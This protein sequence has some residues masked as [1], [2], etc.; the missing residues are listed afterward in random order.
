MSQPE[1]TQSKLLID[2]LCEQ[3]TFPDRAKT[4]EDILVAMESGM[5]KDTFI[6]SMSILRRLGM[7]IRQGVQ[8][9]GDYMAAT[10]IDALDERETGFVVDVIQQTG[11]SASYAEELEIA[12]KKYPNLRNLA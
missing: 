12:Y 7:K 9:I 11:S 3:K 6:I 5:G 4:Q 2:G 10:G 8:L 1:R